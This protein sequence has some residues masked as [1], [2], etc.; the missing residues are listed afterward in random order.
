DFASAFA[1]N[2]GQIETG[3]DVTAVGPHPAR[4]GRDSVGPETA[5]QFPPV[6]LGFRRAFKSSLEA[7]GNFASLLGDGRRLIDGNLPIAHLFLDAWHIIAGLGRVDHLTDAA[8]ALW[9]GRCTAIILVTCRIVRFRTRILLRFTLVIGLWLRF[10]LAQVVD[11]LGA[12]PAKAWVDEH[13][14]RQTETSVEQQRVDRIVAG[15]VPAP[16]VALGPPGVMLERG[17]HDLVSQDPSQR[18]R[19][20]RI[21]EHRVV[22]EYNPVSRHSRNRAIFFALQPEQ[23]RPEEGMIEQK[24]RARFADAL[25]RRVFVSHAAAGASMYADIWSKIPWTE[26]ILCSACSASRLRIASSMRE[27]IPAAS[28]AVT[29]RSNSCFLRSCAV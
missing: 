1:H 10:G 13:I 19:I 20:Q 14:V 2:A 24:R 23:Q 26:A 28:V 22:A 4:I 25:G 7:G 3:P 18:R 21:D 5:Q 9:N 12:H 8:P 17:M 15:L 11:L 6:D 27:T 16:G 29:T